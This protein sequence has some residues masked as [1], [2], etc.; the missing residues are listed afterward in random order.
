MQL[1]RWLKFS[2]QEQIRAIAAE[3]MRAQVWQNK[4]RNNFKSAIE[5]AIDMLDCSIGD[6]KWENQKSMLFWLRNKLA[7]FYT[8]IENKNSISVLYN[9]L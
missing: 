8:G 9:I 6:Q 1:E 7:E 5:R 3:I 4:D 2:K